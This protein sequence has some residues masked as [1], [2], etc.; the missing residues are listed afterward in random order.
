MKNNP[1]YI[2]WVGALMANQ[3][4][5]PYLSVNG[6][7]I[8][9][10]Q[11]L[12]YIQFKA[13]ACDLITDEILRPQKNWYAFRDGVESTLPDPSPKSRELQ[14]SFGGP[15]PTSLEGDYWEL[16]SK[17]ILDFI[18]GWEKSQSSKPDRL[19]NLLISFGSLELVD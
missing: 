7:K 4:L 19:S 3:H 9:Y 18:Q 15:L 6:G 5:V 8:E 17:G 10:N 2:K 14:E 11:V 12:D 1:E 16:K 13:V